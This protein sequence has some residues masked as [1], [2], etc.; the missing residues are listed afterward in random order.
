[1]AVENLTVDRTT[2]RR[3]VRA[4]APEFRRPLQGSVKYERTTWLMDETYIRLAAPVPPWSTAAGE[5]GRF[6][7]V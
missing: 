4:Y 7:P 1:M 5:H 6:I 3:W 2:A